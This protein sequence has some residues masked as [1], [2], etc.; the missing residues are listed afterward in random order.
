MPVT[1]VGSTLASTIITAL[2]ENFVLPAVSL[3]DPKFALPSQVDNPLYA[4]V[5]KINIADLTSGAVGGEGAFDKMMESHKA[6]LKEQFDQGRITGDQYSKAYIEL[7]TA[8]LGAAV[9]MVLGRDQAYW[10]AVLVQTQ[11]RRAEVEAVTAAVGL[12]T[13]KAQLALTNYQAQAAKSQAVLTKMQIATEDA[14][15]RLTAEQYE[16]AAYTTAQMLPVQKAFLQEQMEAKR[17]ETLD[18]RT[19]N[20]TVTGMV[21]KQKLLYD[22]QIDSYKKDA[23]YKVGKLFSDSWLTQ[24]TINENLTA[25]SNFTNTDIDQVLTALRTGT[26]L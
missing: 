10:N 21:G 9:Q 15:Y 24:K 6:H 7:T 17:A 19:D 20:V 3:S 14:K 25:P 26:N 2:G 18:K 4:G 1:V 23:A 11:A 13:A 8:A 16:Q 12:E 22:E 5:D